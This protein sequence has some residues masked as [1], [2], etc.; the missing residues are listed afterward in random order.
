MA[1][2]LKD[3]KRLKGGVSSVRKMILDDNVAKKI[4]IPREDFVYCRTHF[5]VKRLTS[6]KS[7]KWDIVSCFNQT[8]GE[9]GKGCPIC[10]EIQKEWDLWKKLPK[11]AKD[12]KKKITDKI[13]QMVAEEYWM[14]AIDLSSDDKK[15]EAVRFT[16]SKM[17]D[18]QRVMEFASLEDIV[19]SY[20]KIV[21]MEGGKKTSTKYALVEDTDRQ[22]LCEKLKAQLDMF[23]G[24]TYEEGGLCDLDAMVRKYDSLDKY[25]AILNGEGGDEEAE[26]HHQDNRSINEPTK[27]AVKAATKKVEVTEIDEEIDLSGFDDKPAKTDELDLDGAGLDLE[28][29]KKVT[30]D[31]EY[32]KTNQKEKNKMGLIYSKM[33]AEKK[34]A[35]VGED[36]ASRVK[37]V[38]AVVK[39]T[40]FEMNETELDIPF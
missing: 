16:N 36:Y 38:Y 6:Y 4:W 34:V 39:V 29:P 32:V 2:S 9:R 3:L 21:T 30:I 28:P 35:D 12:D 33:L 25:M 31:A 19:W 11:D 7:A 13:N 17:E 10:A 24:R 37:A 1:H 40:P 22:D 14:N 26:E 8:I 27:A 18:I 20:K 15:F 5:N 23:V